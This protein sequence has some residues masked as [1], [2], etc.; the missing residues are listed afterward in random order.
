MLSMVLHGAQDIR[1]LC[2]WNMCNGCLVKIRVFFAGSCNLT[3]DHC[4]YCSPK[5]YDRESKPRVRLHNRSQAIANISDPTSTYPHEKT[6][7]IWQSL[8]V[9]SHNDLLRDIH[10]PTFNFTCPPPFAAGTLSSHHTNF[11]AL[12]QSSCRLTEEITSSESKLTRCRDSELGNTH[13]IYMSVPNRLCSGG[14]LQ[15]TYQ[16]CTGFLGRFHTCSD[17]K[18]APR[19]WFVTP[20]ARSKLSDFRHACA[21]STQESASLPAVSMT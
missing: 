5:A 21:I 20:E 6:R 4:L 18:H 12:N 15:N 19:T 3:H 14:A 10:Y 13:Q 1:R 2:S 7:H 11:L 17:P 9:S 8:R 16:T